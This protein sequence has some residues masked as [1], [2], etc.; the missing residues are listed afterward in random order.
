MVEESDVF[1]INIIDI[2]V[3]VVVVFNKDFN[4]VGVVLLDSIV[5]VRVVRRMNN[6]VKI[7]VNMFEC[8][9]MNSMIMGIIIDIFL[10][11]Y[12]IRWMKKFIL[13]EI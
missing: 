8:F 4:D 5:R 11:R 7:R 9:I 13:G 10:N 1:L 6:I 12:V 3:Y 2:V